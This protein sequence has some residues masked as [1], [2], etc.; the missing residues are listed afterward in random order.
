MKQ[1]FFIISAKSIVNNQNIFR[2]LLIYRILLL[3][4]KSILLVFLLSYEAQ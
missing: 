3:N 1:L 2:I 4:I